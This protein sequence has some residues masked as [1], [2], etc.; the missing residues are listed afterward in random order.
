MPFTELEF[1]F[2]KQMRQFYTDLSK[3]LDRLTLQE[4]LQ[5][6]NLHL[7]R[8]KSQD[9]NSAGSLVRHLID[10]HLSPHEQALLAPIIHQV[11]DLEQESE[12][13]TT[14]DAKKIFDN[15][16]YYAKQ[17]DQS[18]QRKRSTIIN[19]LTYDFLTTYCHNGEIDWHK[20]IDAQG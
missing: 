15:I 3:I 12:A 8:L 20:I 2:D 11:Q 14:M 9:M 13:D 6:Q 17:N 19:R 18:F 4:L 5:G 16:Y 1:H 10:E 7:L